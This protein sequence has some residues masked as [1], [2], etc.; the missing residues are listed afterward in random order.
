MGAIHTRC[1]RIFLRFSTT[2]YEQ[3]NSGRLS[4]QDPKLSLLKVAWLLERW[5]GNPC[6]ITPLVFRLKNWRRLRLMNDCYLTLIWT[7]KLILLLMGIY[8][9]HVCIFSH[10]KQQ[11]NSPRKCFFLPSSNLFEVIMHRCLYIIQFSSWKPALNFT[12]ILRKFFSN[13]FRYPEKVWVQDFNY[14]DKC[15]SFIYRTTDVEDC[16]NRMPFICEIDPKVS[17]NHGQL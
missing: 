6:V 5:Q 17:K 12:P 15:T 7:N 9:V 1:R 10:F 13:N 11:N 16:N 4:D 14:I 3:K 8:Y 2:I